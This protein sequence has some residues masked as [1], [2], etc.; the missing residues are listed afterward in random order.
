MVR[1]NRMMVRVNHAFHCR[2]RFCRKTEFAQ[3][4]ICRGTTVS[5]CSLAP[6]ALNS[7]RGI[8]GASYTPVRARSIVIPQAEVRMFGQWDRTKLGVTEDILGVYL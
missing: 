7:G 6:L 8:L 2:I 3:R 5:E 4:R 1:V